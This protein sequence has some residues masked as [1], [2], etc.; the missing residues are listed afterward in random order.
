LSAHQRYRG[1]VYSLIEGVPGQSQ[2]SYPSWEAALR[3]YLEAYNAGILHEKGGEIDDTLLT[4][5]NQIGTGAS[6]DNSI[7]SEGEFWDEADNYDDS[8]LFYDTDYF[9]ADDDD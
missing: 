7:D 5:D 3:A 1:L 9:Y 6:D 4:R 8:G 2:C